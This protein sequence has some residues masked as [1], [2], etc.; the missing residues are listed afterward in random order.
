ML[1]M[2]LLVIT[3]SRIVSDHWLTLIEVTPYVRDTARSVTCPCQSDVCDTSSR[4]RGTYLSKKV[5]L[6]RELRTPFRVKMVWGFTEW[7]HHFI[8]SFLIST[9]VLGLPGFFTLRPSV[10]YTSSITPT[11][12]SSV[13]SKMRASV[14]YSFMLFLLPL[15][16]ASPIIAPENETW[17]V[18]SLEMHMMTADSGLP[19]GNWPD[20]YTPPSSLHLNV[21]PLPDPP[22]ASLP[23]T[24]PTCTIRPNHCPNT[25][26]R[27]NTTIAM[28]MSM[29]HEMLIADVVATV[30]V[31]ATCGAEWANGTLPRGVGWECAVAA[32]SSDLVTN[33]QVQ[34]DLGMVAFWVEPRDG[35]DGGA[36]AMV[37][38]VEVVREELSYSLHISRDTREG[39]DGR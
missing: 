22:F 11:P 14:M 29:T 16:I 35:E 13:R 1:D 25:R 28:E 8:C 37:A 17:N 3:V 30:N 33:E 34:D 23:L 4:L 21:Q 31:T 10:T 6:D 19:G 15:T 36:R 7:W 5:T 27:F 38:G 24:N 9:Q 32:N 18:S 26:Y 39:G 12:L 20:R 2:P